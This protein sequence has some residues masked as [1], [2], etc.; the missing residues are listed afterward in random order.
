MCI[1]GQVS[2]TTVQKFK[3]LF[4]RFVFLPLLLHSSIDDKNHSCSTY[5]LIH[6]KWLIQILLQ[7]VF[8][9]V[10]NLLLLWKGKCTPEGP[11]RSN[12]GKGPPT[13]RSPVRVSKGKPGSPCSK[14]SF[15]NLCLLLRSL[16]RCKIQV[17]ISAHIVW[18]L[19][20]K[21]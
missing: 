18:G 15:R 6:F 20:Y 21:Q 4:D 12:K 2:S 19:S 17:D 13:A 14:S 10:V 8:P 5:K 9:S 11:V 1:I 3:V 7:S 16:F